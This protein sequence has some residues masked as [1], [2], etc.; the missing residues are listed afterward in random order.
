MPLTF[1]LHTSQ[2]LPGDHIGNILN[3]EANALF[4]LIQNRK[5]K[6]GNLINIMNFTYIP[7]RLNY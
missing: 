4:D 2:V 3:K 6:K 7:N 1:V 5:G